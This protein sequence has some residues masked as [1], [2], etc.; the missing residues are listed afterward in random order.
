MPFLEWDWRGDA[1]VNHCSEPGQANTYQRGTNPTPYVYLGKVDLLE[2]DGTAKIPQVAKE[3][4]DNIKHLD[5][6]FWLRIDNGPAVKINSSGHSI[7]TTNGCDI[8]LNESNYVWNDNSLL[9]FFFI[10]PPSGNKLK[11]YYHDPDQYKEEF[12]GIYIASGSG[13]TGS[14]AIIRRL[15]QYGNPTSSNPY[16]LHIR[17]FYLNDRDANRGV[18]KYY[19]GATFGKTSQPQCSITSR[20]KVIGV[21]VLS[22]TRCTTPT[23]TTQ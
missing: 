1:D 2:P 13:S 21:S 3:V 11:F 20:L 5:K 10:N 23:N 14:S 22:A 12:K 4:F 15:D 8:D 18:S 17:E 16:G 7:S 19:P 9:K 6:D